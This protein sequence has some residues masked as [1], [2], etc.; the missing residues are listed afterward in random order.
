MHVKSES[1][2]I[3]KLNGFKTI[4]N[5]SNKGTSY[6][7]LDINQNQHILADFK[8]WEFPSRLVIQIP[9]LTRVYHGHSFNKLTLSQA[10][11][12]LTNIADM[13]G[14][15]LN[16]LQITNLEFGANVEVE[17]N[18]SSYIRYYSDLN[19]H[20]RSSYKDE[21]L[22]FSIQKRDFILYD[23]V[24]KAKAKR[25]LEPIPKA[26][27]KKNIIRIELKLHD[28]TKEFGRK[29]Y[30]HDLTD[31]VFFLTLCDKWYNFSQTILTEKIVSGNPLLTA[32][33]KKDFKDRLMSIGIQALG[34]KKV[35]SA[36]ETIKENDVF[37][38]SNRITYYSFKQHLNRLYNLPI[39]AN[40]PLVD[41]LSAKVKDLYIEIKDDVEKL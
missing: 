33:T 13:F 8:I 3:L 7:T 12:A 23:K 38:Y 6:L 19:R 20:K 25:F 36:Y 5:T 11:D 10:T 14:L 39:S 1:T 37:C 18:V 15:D 32:K 29:I 24:K 30:A 16:E 21:T 40:P 4:Q 2:S 22:V 9:S 31:K 28:P 17:N 35:L 34:L 41:E 27:I 26:C